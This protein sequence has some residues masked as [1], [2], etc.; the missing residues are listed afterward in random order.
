VLYD[1]PIEVKVGDMVYFDYMQH[2]DCYQYQRFIE[3]ELGD[4]LLMRYDSLILAH[5]EENPQDIKTLNGLILIEK[6]AEKEGKS[7]A[8]IH[9]PLVKTQKGRVGKFSY[10]TVVKTGNICRGYLDDLEVCDD[11][12]PLNEG[13][14]VIYKPAG[15]HLLEWGLHQVLFGGREVYSIHRKDLLMVMPKCEEYAGV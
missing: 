11:P 7:K 6:E 9:L 8:G 3:T 10:A 4:M 1:V 13:D 12:R 5:S 2:Y 14:C 15:A